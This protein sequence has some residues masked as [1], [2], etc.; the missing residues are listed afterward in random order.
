MIP[1]SPVD[2]AGGAGW[3]EIQE[4]HADGKLAPGVS[5]TYF[6]T[7]RPVYELYDLESDPSELN[8]LSGK[9]VRQGGEGTAEALAEKMILDWDYLP[10]PDLMEGGQKG[11]QKG[12][13]GKGK[14]KVD[15]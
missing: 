7:P 13:K 11:G 4:A 5:S 6:T 2:S 10:L 9:A 1:Y 3:K 12:G 14:G 15:A 8:N